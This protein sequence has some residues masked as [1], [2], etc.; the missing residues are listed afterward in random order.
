MTANNINSNKISWPIFTGV[1]E[2]FAVFS[3]RHAVFMNYRLQL[4]SPMLIHLQP[5]TEERQSYVAYQIGKAHVLAN[6]LA[7]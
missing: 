6:V 7:A 2:I 1:L 4:D 3:T 5:T